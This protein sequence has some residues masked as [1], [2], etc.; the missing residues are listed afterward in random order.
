MKNIILI[1]K[2]E[3]LTQV[4]K[5]SFIVLTLLA[6]LLLAGFIALITF[7]FKANETQTKLSVIDKSGIF[8][9]QLKSDKD[10]QYTFVP[11]ETE[12]SL[13]VALKN[14]EDM[15]GVLVIPANTDNNLDALEKNSKLYINKKLGFDA[16]MKITSQVKSMTIQ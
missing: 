9:T 15:D 14:V 5:K 2:R 3:F 12:K 11:S 6:P 1:T 7:M 10:I 4:K 16:Q 8:A 13:L